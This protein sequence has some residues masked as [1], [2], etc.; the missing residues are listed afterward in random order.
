M[1][2]GTKCVELKWIALDT[3][4]TRDTAYESGVV[5]FSYNQFYILADKCGR[6]VG[7]VWGYQEVKG[8][9]E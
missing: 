5:S 1:V 2:R 8:K 9:G 3:V 4:C 6:G 7:E